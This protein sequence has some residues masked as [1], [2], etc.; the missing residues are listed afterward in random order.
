MWS[1]YN[2]HVE[3]AEIL[4]KKESS[5]NVYDD[6]HMTCL[7][8]ASGRGFEDVVALLIRYGAKVD[9]GDKYGTTSLIWSARK[10]Y[11]EIVRKLLKAGAGVDATGMF[12]WNPLIVA[13]RGNFGEIV[14]MILAHKPNVNSCDPTGLTPLMTASKEGNIDIVNSLLHANSY[15]NLSD[16]NGDT[17]LI[18]AAKAGHV[19]VVE[20]L[21]KAHADVDHQSGGEDRKTALYWAV[22]K[23]HV[24]VTR[25]LLKSNPNLEL[26]TIDGDT[27]LLKAVRNRKLQLVKML[28]EKKARVSVVDKYGDCAL[29]IAARAQSKAILELILRNPKNSQMLYKPNKRG[30]TPFLLD[31][32]HQKPVLPTL[33]G[34][35][36]SSR[37]VLEKETQLG[38]DLY[39]SAIA[40]LLSEPTLK[41]PICIGLFAKWGSGKSF[42]IG[43]LKEDLMTITGQSWAGVSPTFK[44]TW[45][46]VLTVI[47]LSMLTG[48]SAL[49]ASGGN[50]LTALLALILTFV[51]SY[52]VLGIIYCGHLYYDWSISRILRKKLDQLKLILQISFADP[53]RI[54][55]DL[56]QSLPVRFLFT[57]SPVKISNDYSVTQFMASLLT[58][59]WIMMESEFGFMPVRLYRVF[60]PKHVSSGTWKW[61]KVCC[62]IPAIGMVMFSFATILL[63]ILL[64]YNYDSNPLSFSPSSNS[65]I[66]AYIL[67]AILS[68]ISAWILGNI[69]IPYKIGKELFFS[70]K[71]LTGRDDIKRE[72][73]LMISCIFCLDAFNGKRQS[74]L[75]IVLDALESIY[76]SERLVSFLEGINMHFINIISSTN[77]CSNVSAS[78]PFVTVMAL[79]PHHHVT[80]KSKEY[81]KTI[82][83]LPFYL[84]NSQLRRVRIAQTT[85]TRVAY[86]YRSSTASIVD[87]LGTGGAGTGSFKGTTGGGALGHARSKSILMK[88]Q[89][90]LH[91]QATT[92]GYTLK[93][94]DSVVSLYGGFGSATEPATKVLLTDDYFS[95]VNPKS[96][97]RIMNIVY[98]QGRL[99]KAF[100]IDFNWHRLTIW[101]NMSEQ[102]PLRLSALIVF[103]EMNE[104]KFNDDNITFKTLYEK[105]LSLKLLI[106]ISSP[107]GSSSGST[108]ETLIQK[109]NE[110]KK[111]L[112]FL[113]FHQHTL[114]LADLKIFS[115]FTINIDPYYRKTIQDSFGNSAGGQS[116][117]PITV[118]S[119]SRAG[120]FSLGP[121][122]QPTLIPALG[123]SSPRETTS[124]HVVT[125]HNRLAELTVDGVINM[126]KSI[127]GF[128]TSMIERKYSKVLKENNIN[129][130]VLSS[131]SP[132]DFDD[133]KH[134]L[135]FSFGDWLLFKKVVSEGK[136]PY[137]LAPAPSG[138]EFQ[139]SPTPLQNMPTASVTSITS[140]SSAPYVAPPQSLPP[141]SPSLSSRM[142]EVKE[143]DDDYDEDACQQTVINANVMSMLLTPSRGTIQSTLEKQVTMEDAALASAVLMTHDDDD[144][145]SNSSH[146]ISSTG[147]LMSSG[148]SST[149]NLVMDDMM[150]EIGVL[151]LAPSSVLNGVISP[152]ISFHD[153]ISIAS[154]KTSINMDGI[155]SGQQANHSSASN[156]NSSHR[157]SQ[158]N[159]DEGIVFTA[160]EP[161]ERTPLVSPSKQSISSSG[162]GSSASGAAGAGRR[163]PSL[164]RQNQCSSDGKDANSS[165]GDVLT[166][167]TQQPSVNSNNCKSDATKRQESIL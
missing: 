34:A 163:R 83:H 72:V 146:Q 52:L 109:D 128:D 75:A 68:I 112:M 35:A 45:T 17:A 121:S 26:A 66:S 60:K 162:S 90:N 137:H 95:D 107:D 157:K 127:D 119:T 31:S 14:D 10:G 96:M 47:T 71:N 15:V 81:L 78:A 167:I 125:S 48:I 165:G 158:S 103:F 77:S 130:K 141:S 16:R 92:T 27:A 117:N 21:I 28:L 120:S 160:P 18:H 74:R 20:A 104:T 82:V 84:Q 124:A 42:L 76:E 166:V 29:H 155:S 4:L 161:D 143:E 8:W 38:Y 136:M 156:H 131:L 24:E 91:H 12:G 101:V 110:E 106:N 98:I 142:T 87:A 145:Q 59:L 97:R 58:S 89:Q 46:S 40:N 108:T 5:P 133:L 64:Y 132:S 118:G 19:L 135:G 144:V 6:N 164:M 126:L 140:I 37:R 93:Q 73:D 23:G 51:I 105:I 134:A 88:K 39:S 151:Y 129:G 138:K 41:T 79:D 2:G 154:S 150:G 62:M 43:K 57:D 36:P 65:P 3:I 159:V 61:R 94:S 116:I 153:R 11:V 54:H 53:P 32:A 69:I 44:F 139:V 30:E 67:V 86:D 149:N 148:M 13:T 55:Y 123:V 56:C 25:A 80:S 99:L 111:F 85:A 33:F 113:S 7:I 152:S 1:C 49:I 9:A 115:P 147:D 102:W 22:E 63:I 100:N 70:R 50:N 122:T 114:C